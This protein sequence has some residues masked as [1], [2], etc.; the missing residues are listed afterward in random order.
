MPRRRGREPYRMNT[1][2]L[3]LAAVDRA[4]AASR[5]D[6]T[7]DRKLDEAQRRR[8]ADRIEN[9]RSGLACTHGVSPWTAC[10]QCSRPVRRP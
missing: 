5:T 1:R 3:E 4:I 9:H 2:L 10:T 6:P 7:I 8:E